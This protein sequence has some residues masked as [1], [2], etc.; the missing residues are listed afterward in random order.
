MTKQEADLTTNMTELARQWNFRVKA[1]TLPGESVCVVGNCEQLG[2]WKSSQAVQLTKVLDSGDGCTWSGVV[3]IPL[4]AVE[5]RYFICVVIEPDVAISHEKRVIIRRWETHWQPRIIPK[6]VTSNVERQV[7]D[8]TF[9]FHDDYSMVDRGWL[10]SETVIQFKIFNSALQFC[11]RK[12]LDKKAYIKI[13]PVIISMPPVANSASFSDSLD[14]SMDTHENGQD[15]IWPIT[16]VAVMNET[17]YEFKL[18]EQFGRAYNPEEFVVFSINVH[19]P[20]NV[21]YLVDVFAHMSLPV[22]GEPPMHIGFGYILPNVLLRSE[23]RAVVPLTDA[24]R[25]PVGELK[26]DFLVVE[27]IKQYDCNMSVSYSRFWKKSWLGL[28]VGHRGLGTSFKLEMQTCADIREN[29][30]ASLKTAASH[31]AD[32]VEFD[33]QLTK[34][35]VPVIYHDFHVCIAMKKKKHLE[36]HDMLQLPVKDLTLEQ[37]RMLKVYHLEEGK[38]RNPRFFD[39]DLEEHQPF[40][41][42]QEALE[43]IDPHVGFNVEI[44]WTME[45]KDGT[46]ELVD[47]FDLNMYLDTVLK[48]IL[49]HGGSR[50]IVFSCFHPD[51]CTMIRLKQNLYPV[52]FLTQGITAKYPPYRDMRTWNIPMAVYYALSAGILGINVHTEDILRDPSQIKLVTD[53]GLIIFC[54]GEDNNDTATIKH[55]KSLGLHAIIYDKIDKFGTKEVKESIFLVEAREGQKNLLQIAQEVDKK[56]SSDNSPLMHASVTPAADY[57]LHISTNCTPLNDDPLSASAVL[58]KNLGSSMDVSEPSTLTSIKSS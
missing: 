4:Q 28:D 1:D 12:Y 18:Q 39:D 37:L 15:N 17:E 52:M 47:P 33:V 3:D 11:R 24:N 41:T 6:N 40:P 45:L 8:E 35:G 44:K 50:K 51:I 56:Q 9:G 48:V 23:G 34:D 14:E 10:T 31:G 53:A 36:Q 32:F 46:Y 25:R 30:I 21:A 19:N 57:Q 26:V 20:K 29:T 5:Y 54:W 38:N 27:P 55:L 22:D 58:M 43:I 42:L 49:Q 16:E 13:T 7:E 2:N